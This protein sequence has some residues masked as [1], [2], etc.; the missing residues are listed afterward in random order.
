MVLHHSPLNLINRLATL[1]VVFAV[2]VLLLLFTGNVLT[3][4]GWL[5]LVAY[6]VI[7]IMTRV[8]AE[9]LTLGDDGFVVDTAMYRMSVPC[10]DVAAVIRRRVGA[11]SIVVV[12][13][14]APAL[15]EV[16]DSTS[17]MQTLGQVRLS[18]T[19]LPVRSTGAQVR[20]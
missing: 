11:N 18:V 15:V 13:L 16:N 20:A 8:L 14:S 4:L 3:T 10:S 19:S 2:G 9:T 6:P 17:E 1:V 12:R 5:A 7:R